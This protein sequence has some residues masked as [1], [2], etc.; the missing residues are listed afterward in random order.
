ME[1][2]VQNSVL[3]YLYTI[4]EIKFLYIS[5]NVRF[6]YVKLPLHIDNEIPIV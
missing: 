1:R 5:V 2:M 6:L 3:L 4:Y